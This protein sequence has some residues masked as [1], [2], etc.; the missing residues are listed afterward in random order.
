MEPDL[1]KPPLGPPE[2]HPGGRPGEPEAAAESVVEGEVRLHL[3][4]VEVGG[5]HQHQG[6][7]HGSPVELLGAA[8]STG[9]GP[10]RARPTGPLRRFLQP[11]DGASREDEEDLELVSEN[12]IVGSAVGRHPFYVVEGG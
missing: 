12:S 7:G 1:G 6:L 2:G 3:P 10:P 5:G 8:G 9:A 4:I 11:I